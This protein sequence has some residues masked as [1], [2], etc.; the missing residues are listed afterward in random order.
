MAVT[1]VN[2]KKNVRA[3][4]PVVANGVLVPMSVYIDAR[5][6]KMSDGTTTLLNALKEIAPMQAVKIPDT[7]DDYVWDLGNVGYYS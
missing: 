1:S 5:D 2:G 4:S 7:E 6:L 3:K